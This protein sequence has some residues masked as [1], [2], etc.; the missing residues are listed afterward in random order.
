MSIFHKWMERGMANQMSNRNQ[1][2]LKGGRSA[3]FTGAAA[4]SAIDVFNPDRLLFD[5]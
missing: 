4:A 2:W 1:W 3:P 5:I